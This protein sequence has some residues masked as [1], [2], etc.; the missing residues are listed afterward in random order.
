MLAW[1][2]TWSPEFLIFHNLFSRKLLINWRFLLYLDKSYFI[3]NSTITVKS[4]LT[5]VCKNFCN[6]SLLGYTL[7]ETT[8]AFYFTWKKQNSLGQKSK[9]LYLHKIDSKNVTFWAFTE[10]LRL[11]SFQEEYYCYLHFYLITKAAYSSASFNAFTVYSFLCG[12][13]QHVK[14]ECQRD[15]KLTNILQYKK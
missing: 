5:A 14:H 1:F 13:F 12:I 4:S 9:A 15:N 11:F 6:L 8:G 7:Q 2:L 10:N 3:I